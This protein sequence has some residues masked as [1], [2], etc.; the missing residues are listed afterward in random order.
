[1]AQAEG[2]VTSYSV[3]TSETEEYT[4][5]FTLEFD[6]PTKTSEAKQEVKEAGLN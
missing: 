1:M 6:E 5:T 3:T 4:S 2:L